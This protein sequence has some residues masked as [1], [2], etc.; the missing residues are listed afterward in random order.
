M[1]EVTKTTGTS[2]VSCT[3]SSDSLAGRRVCSSPREPVYRAF[4]FT[5]PLSLEISFSK[6]E[7]QSGCA[8]AF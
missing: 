5:T 3:A 8:T 7:K 6:D 1:K 2:E 4:N